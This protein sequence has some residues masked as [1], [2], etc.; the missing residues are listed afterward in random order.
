MNDAISNFS[1][2]RKA[3]IP[4]AGFGTRMFPATKAIKKEFFPIIDREGRT[5]PIILAIVEEAIQAG[6]EEVSIVIQERDRP[7]FEEFFKTP[8]SPELFDKLKPEAREYCQYLQTLGDKITLLV[9]DVADG[10]G[11]AVFC[12]K[13]WVGNEPFL[14]L[15]GDHIYTSFITKNCASQLLSVYREANQSVIGMR[16]ASTMEIQHYGCMT[17][18]WQATDAVLSITQIYEKPTPEYARDRLRVRGMAEDEFLAVFGMY[19]L[20]PTIFEVLEN[21][22]Q[23]NLREDGE[24]QLTSCLEKMRQKEG[25]TGYLIKGRCFDVGLPDVYRNT[26]ID[27]RGGAIGCGDLR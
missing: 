7:L 26:I 1:L 27:F 21:T 16:V 23:N 15:L 10:F 24:F 4:A 12:A 13:N 8:P 14:L 25:M 18:K 19:I 9:Q 5:K 3:V 17:G 22:I 2:V 20:T 6:I 11:Y